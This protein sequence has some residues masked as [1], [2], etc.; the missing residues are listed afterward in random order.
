MPSGQY[1]TLTLKWGTLKAWDFTKSKKAQALIEQWASLG[2]CESSA[3]HKDTIEQ[4]ELIFQI[5]DECNDPRGIYLD[6]CNKY[7]SKK[8]AKEYIREYDK[9]RH[10]NQS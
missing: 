5:I 1:N 9:V 3:A 7:V 4:R 8:E 6:F 10:D 2:Y